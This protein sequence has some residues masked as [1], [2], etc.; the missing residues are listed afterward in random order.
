MFIRCHP[1]Q[2]LVDGITNPATPVFSLIVFAYSANSSYVCGAFT[3]PSAFTK[4]ASLKSLLLICNP[5]AYASVGKPQIS[6]FPPVTTF[7]I[8]G[9]KILSSPVSF[10]FFE[11]SAQYPASDIVFISVK[12][13]LHVVGS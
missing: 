3:V 8:S 5:C 12:N 7:I 11:I 2:L 6:P 13:V 1:P 4:P 10:R 9:F